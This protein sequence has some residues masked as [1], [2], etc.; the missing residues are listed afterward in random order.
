[1]LI[2]LV[3]YLVELYKTKHAQYCD[4]HNSHSLLRIRVQSCLR[5]LL[6]SEQIN[7]TQLG[8]TAV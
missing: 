2:K 7:S 6:H 3:F 8:E 1:M 5:I 4:Y